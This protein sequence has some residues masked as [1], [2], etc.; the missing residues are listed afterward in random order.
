VP[1][2]GIALV[3]LM[4]YVGDY[5][6]Y[7]QD[8]VATEAYLGTARRRISVKRHARLVDYAMHDGCS[9]RAWVQVL[10]DDTVP[11]AGVLL[12]RVDPITDVPTRFLTRVTGP[13]SMDLAAS[14]Q[15]IATERPEVFEPLADITLFKRHDRL[16]FYTWG[17]EDCCLPEGATRATLD[18]KIATL[19]VGDVLILEEVVGPGPA[20][21]PT[22]TGSPARRAPDRGVD[23]DRST[24][25]R[26][27]HAHRMG[28]GRRAPVPAVRIRERDRRERR[29]DRGHDRRG[30]G[31]H[32]AV[33]HG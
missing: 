17:A 20:S 14:D 25:R 22:P 26:R 10:V 32:R 27:H 31:Q 33:D 1:D 28:Q 12:P 9:A 13:A 2:V 30:V 5:L 21:R 7:R 24:R 23:R 3:E 6:A 29:S 16:D 11:A 15:A 8:A 4:A 19:A 18:G